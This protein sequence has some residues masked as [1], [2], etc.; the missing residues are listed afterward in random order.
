MKTFQQLYENIT[1]TML[2]EASLKQLKQIYVD[3]H[4]ID[5]NTFKKI[6]DIDVSDTNKYTQWM[7]KRYLDKNEDRSKLLSIFSDLIPKFN[8]LSNKKL[9]KPKEKDIQI[10]KS[11]EQLY[12][13]LKHYD[14]DKLSKSQISKGVKNF[15]SDIDPKDVVFSNDKVVIVQPKKTDTSCKYGAGT[16]WCTAARGHSNYF[17]QYFYQSNV[18]LYYILPKNKNEEKVAVAVYENGHMEIY[19]K[20]DD[21]ISKQ[22]FEKI[23]KN[24]D[25]PL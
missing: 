5:S 24:W 6:N 18:T 2:C 13:V 17:N 22:E 1:E 19:N 11:T 14:I 16:K 10:Y 25:I 7:I 8:I 20:E 15:D 12:D 21:R 4:K 23:S 3:T 9:L